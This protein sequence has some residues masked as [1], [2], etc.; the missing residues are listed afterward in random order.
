MELLISPG[1]QVHC[2]YD[3]SI[4]LHVL[5]SPAIR[6][7]SQVEPDDTGQWWADL[8]TMNGPQ[9]GP[10]LLRSAALHAEREWLAANWL[11]CSGATDNPIV[12]GEDYP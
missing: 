8:R 9:L 11:Y 2:L 5:G 6:R 4:D 3:E 12:P 10:F 1:G 7:A